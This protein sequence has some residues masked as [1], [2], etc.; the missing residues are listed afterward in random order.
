M[1][2]ETSGSEFGREPNLRALTRHTIENNAPKSSPTILRITEGGAEHRTAEEEAAG[3][4][5]RDQDSA[6][7]LDVESAP[8]RIIPSLSGEVRQDHAP[9]KNISSKAEKGQKRESPLA[10]ENLTN[11]LSM[12]A[13]EICVPPNRR[14]RKD[15]ELL[16]NDNDLVPIVRTTLENL[17]QILESGDPELTKGF[18]REK[19]CQM[20]RRSLSAEKIFVTEWLEEVHKRLS[21]TPA[22]E[23]RK[24]S[25]ILKQNHKIKPVNE[26][27]KT[28]KNS[29]G[30]TP[31]ITS[32]ATTVSIPAPKP[33]AQTFMGRSIRRIRNALFATAAFFGLATLA[34]DH[35]KD[36]SAQ[37][38]RTEEA[39]PEKASGP[40]KKTT[41]KSREV[42]KIG[43]GIESPSAELEKTYAASLTHTVEK[44]ETLTSITFDMM[45]DAGLVSNSDRFER[46]MSSIVRE[47][48]LDNPNALQ[49][50]QELKLSRATKLIDSW[51][52][53]EKQAQSSTIE[54]TSSKIDAATA[55]PDAPSTEQPTT[56]PDTVFNA[57][58][59]SS[60][61]VFSQEYL[62]RYETVSSLAKHMLEAADIKYTTQRGNL[63]KNA[64]LRE[65]G[66]TE[67]EAA[68]LRYEGQKAKGRSRG[69]SEQDRLV[70]DFEKYSSLL[71]DIKKGQDSGKLNLGAVAKKHGLEDLYTKPARPAYLD[72]I[73]TER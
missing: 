32:S 70:T 46:L 12:Q 69:V 31:P 1:T 4:E 30:D 8:I 54:Q 47:S 52:A 33:E 28:P 21:E 55:T 49:I 2:K 51:V 71:E 62:K 35:Y 20:E 11:L 7:P 42:R 56:T 19:I 39:S 57:D 61:P 73:F 6:P 58:E 10:N 44:G 36:S 23:L 41:P 17:S 45:Q 67:E 37:K 43:G 38:E 3:E 34:V 65:S 40:E 26:T 13:D 22:S 50:G 18:I 68:K 53:L 14:L 5:T 9:A 25:N 63:I 16:P 29:K 27:P 48:D 59:V 15:G 64:I 60:H 24:I 66:L 72:D